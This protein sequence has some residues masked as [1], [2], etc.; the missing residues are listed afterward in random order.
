MT[1]W[2]ASP[3]NATLIGLS[4]QTDAIYEISE[5]NGL[6]TYLYQTGGNFAGVGLS[7]IG[8]RLF[9][10]DNM[11][12]IGEPWDFRLAELNLSDQTL[13]N[14]NNQ[15]GALNWHG[16]ASNQTA[17]VLYALDNGDNYILKEISL[18]GSIRNIGTGSGIDGRGMDYDDTHGI[19]YA[20]HMETNS[21]YRVDIQTGTSTLNG[22]MG[23]DAE[24]IGLA[25]NEVT[26]TLY[27]NTT[28]NAS[29]E[30]Y[31]SSL[32]RLNVETGSATFI[33]SNEANRIDGLAWIEPAASIPEP[34][35]VALFGIGGLA[36]FLSGLRRGMGS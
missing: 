16:L 26:G 27:A 18:D 4:T 8:D 24:L 19:L 13:S 20:T 33:G 32:Y 1:L 10:T 30:G 3:S 7:F 34:G 25:Y 35:T 11:I 6:A 29:R 9:A 17:Q 15:G 23:I 22:A 2:V 14:L 12:H 36:L 31:V 5:E 21:L 28:I